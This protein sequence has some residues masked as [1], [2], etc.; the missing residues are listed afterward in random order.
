MEILDVLTKL[1]STSVTH[2]T[3]QILILL[4]H[5]ETDPRASVKRQAL[6]DLRILAEGEKW[7]HLWTREH[8]ERLV[9]INGNVS[10]V[11]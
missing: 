8:L 9:R 6:N 4:E 1:T 5:L 2:V 10:D 3:S 7:A 11:A